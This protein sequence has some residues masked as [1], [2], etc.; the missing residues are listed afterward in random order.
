VIMFATNAELLT[1]HK[2][3]RHNRAAASSSVAG[4]EL[5]SRRLRARQQA[6]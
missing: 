6:R 3:S 1:L 4:D 5:G 2:S